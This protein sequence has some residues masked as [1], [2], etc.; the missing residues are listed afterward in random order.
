MLAFIPNLLTLINLLSGSSA[1][2][3]IFL[4]KPEYALGCHAISLLTDLFD[5]WLARKLK[6]SGPLGVQLDSL[7]DIVSFGVAPAMIAMQ[8]LLYSLNLDIQAGDISTYIKVFWVMILAGSSALRLAK[9]NISDFSGNQFIGMP[10]PPMA[11]FFFGL[12][13][14][15]RWGSVDMILLIREPWFICLCVLYF[16]WVMNSKIPHFKFA[17][18]P[19]TFKNPIIVLWA[20]ITIAM[21]IFLPVAALAGSILIYS[22]LAIIATFVPNKQSISTK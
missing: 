8:L 19:D 6:V 14:I 5:G 11:M 1:I 22:L 12:L 4:E 9:F 15:H 17:L 13:L 20:G 18:H 3:F 2:V 16:T 10:T 7:A 21:A